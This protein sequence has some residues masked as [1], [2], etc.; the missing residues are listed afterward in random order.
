MLAGGR[1]RRCN[2]SLNRG[3]GEE[4]DSQDPMAASSTVLLRTRLPQT[5]NSMSERASE[6]ARKRASERAH[7]GATAEMQ[8]EE[9]REPTFTAEVHTTETSLDLKL[10]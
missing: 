10:T 7:Q 8:I 6:R 3:E 4:G 2:S 1:A 9:I 5:H